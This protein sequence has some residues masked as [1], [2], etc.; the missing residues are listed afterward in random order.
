MND[1]QISYYRS[2]TGVFIPCHRVTRNDGQLGGYVFG[3][4]VK[5]ALLRREGVELMS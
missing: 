3:P 1:G 4:A 2:L 5:Q